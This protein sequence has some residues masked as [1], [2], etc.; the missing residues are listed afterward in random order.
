MDLQLSFTTSK[1]DNLGVLVISLCH[2]LAFCGEDKIVSFSEMVLLLSRVARA[3]NLAACS[4]VSRYIIVGD[5]ENEP[6][7]RGYLVLGAGDDV[8]SRCGC[9]GLG[10]HH[11]N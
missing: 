9:A 8:K 1:G 6:L 3:R 7:L 5:L 10:Q 11:A 2:I 4:F